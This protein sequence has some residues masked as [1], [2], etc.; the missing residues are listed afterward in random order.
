MIKLRDDKRYQKYTDC[1]IK[2][3]SEMDLKE[4]NPEVVLEL[5]ECIKHNHPK[6][7]ALYYMEW[8]QILRGD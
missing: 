8:E 3:I 7:F 6:E 4:W 5:L 1:E 2:R